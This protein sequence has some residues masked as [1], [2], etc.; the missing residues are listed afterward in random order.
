MKLPEINVQSSY[1]TNEYGKIFYNTLIAYRPNCPVEL[2]VLN[3]YSTIYIGMALKYVSENLGHKR[4]LYSYDIF[5]DYQYNHGELER[6]RKLVSDF[7]LNEYISLNKKDAFE[8]YKDYEPWQVDF[9]HVDLSNTGK[10]FKRIIEQWDPVLRPNGM[11]MFEGGSEE[12]DNVEWM[13]KYKKEPI[14]PAIEKDPE[15]TRRY[16]YGTYWPFPSLTVLIK[17]LEKG[18]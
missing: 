17:K 2:G 11:I 18:E 9:L 14:K 6:V 5:E 7:D 8:V 3:G 15:I 16:I 4:C 12:R 13:K 10:T 1:A